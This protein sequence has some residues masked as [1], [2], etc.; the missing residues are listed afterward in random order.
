MK[1]ISIPTRINI[2]AKQCQLVVDFVWKG[3]DD[4]GN[5]KGERS[6]I[7]SIYRIICGFYWIKKIIKNF[8]VEILN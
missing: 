6:G 5:Q 1:K 7:A 2:L 3:V 8:F 4:E